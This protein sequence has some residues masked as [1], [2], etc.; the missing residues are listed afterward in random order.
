MTTLPDDMKLEDLEVSR[1][2]LAKA[3]GLSG[4]RVGQLVAEGILPAGEH[5][6]YPLVAC[7]EA[8]RVR[9]KSG[10][11]AKDRAAFISART[12][13][14]E[15]K[16]ETA[17]IEREERLGVLVNGEVFGDVMIGFYSVVG[18]RLLGLPNMLGSHFSKLRSG[19]E[20]FDWLQKEIYA[21]LEQ[22]SEL[23]S[24][25]LVAEATRKR[26]DPFEERPPG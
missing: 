22:L 8:D 11:S 20:A 18:T 6:K 14:L 16:A 2:E 7:L 5:G 19:R 13:L 26:R 17:E 9:R 23:D 15:A 12:R 25:G 1:V 3:L 24:A 10:E 4:S 21:A